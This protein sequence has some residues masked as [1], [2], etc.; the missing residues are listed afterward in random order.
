MRALLTLASLLALLAGCGDSSSS[1]G[2]RPARS[3]GGEA[4]EPEEDRGAD[5]ADEARAAYE[6][7]LEDFEDNDCIAAEP[8]FRTI[9]REYPYSRY[10]ALAQL[11]IGDCQMDQSEYAEAVQSFSSF[12]RYNASHPQV[13]YARFRIAEA[14]YEQIP[15]DWLLVPPSYER[16]LGSAQDALRYLRRFILDYPE[17][18]HVPQAIE[19]AR[20]SLFV[21]AGHELYA[22]RYYL[23]RGAPEAAVLRLESLIER[24]EGSEH[25]A[26]AWLSLGIA[27][28]ELEA[29][30][31]ARVAFE[32]VIA[33]WPGTDHAE[34][35]AERLA[36]LPPAPEP[37]PEGAPEPAAESEAEPEAP[38][39]E[40]PAEEAPVEESPAEE[41]PTTP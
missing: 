36:D 15:T 24:Y 10:A 28:A 1:E 27:Y 5:Y 34:D 11:R 38:V 7:A 18:E 31:R 21:L 14:H 26:L 22:A 19:M 3:S 8:A 39:E 16:D 29:P 17:D 13:P 9:R 32:T 37:E 25:D 12:V 35:A 40:A 23:R 2:E 6:A 30:R 4:E 33:R 20:R 41:A